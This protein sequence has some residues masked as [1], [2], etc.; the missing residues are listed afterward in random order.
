MILLW[1][2]DLLDS[3]RIAGHGKAVGQTVQTCRNLAVLRGA[4]AAQPTCVILD[5]HQAGLDPA[6]LVPE[7]RAAGVRTIIG[8]GSHVDTIRLKAA[9]TA[10][11][12][13]VLPRS[14]FFEDLEAHLVRWAT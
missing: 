11:C 5:L 1:N 2:D 10:G 3:S 8:Y 4:L 9:R 13:E 6:T 7:L 14:A 12:D